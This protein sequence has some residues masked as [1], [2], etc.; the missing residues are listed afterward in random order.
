[1][2]SRFSIEAV[3]GVKGLAAHNLHGSDA[4]VDRLRKP[5]RQVG[6]PL[7]WLRYHDQG[8]LHD[9]DCRATGAWDEPVRRTAAEARRTA[10]E[11]VTP[12]L[13]EWVDADRGFVSTVWWE[14]MR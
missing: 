2:K 11:L 10:V 3:T 5:E 6:L 1:L 7:L 13:G 9:M 4:R 8:A 14:A 12:R